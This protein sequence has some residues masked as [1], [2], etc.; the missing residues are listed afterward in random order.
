MPSPNASVAIA[1]LRPDIYGLMEQFSLSENEQKM[2]G[3]TV[4]PVKEVGLRASPY[5]KITVESLMKAVDTTRT[6]KGGYNETEFE[7]TTDSYATN[8]NGIEAPI[9]DRDSAL[10]ANYF[11]SEM[12][13][14]QLARHTVLLNR[15]RRVAAKTFDIGTFTTTAVINEWDDAANCTPITDIETEVQAM[16]GKGVIPNAL[17]INW[18]VFRNLRNSAQVIAR[19]TANGAGSPAKP[20]D[21]TLQMLAAVFDLPKIIVGGAQYNAAKEGQPAN[22]LPIWSGE[23]AA[24]ARVSDGGPS[25]KD[26]CVGRT[27]HWGGDGSNINLAYETYYDIRR[28][29]NIVRARNETDEKVMYA[30]SCR[31]L[32]NIT[33]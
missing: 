30:Q 25:I 9:D 10:Y 5:G 33:T 32:S 8:E 20:S 22:L 27:F 24:V 2:I 3:L 28:R 21:V 7:F 23:Y 26:P 18:L 19:I 11:D 29:G 6:S 15:E 1:T 17:I 31:L 12:E 13:A 4:F 16:Y 14:A